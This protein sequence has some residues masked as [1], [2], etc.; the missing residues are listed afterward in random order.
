MMQTLRAFFIVALLVTGAAGHAANDTGNTAA[1]VTT[2]LRV[3]G[4]VKT[5]LVLGVDALRKLSMQHVGKLPL[6]CQ[7]GAEVG[8]LDNLGGVLLRDVLEQAVL[9]A[10]GHN[11]AKKMVIVATA[12]DGYRVVFSWGEVFNSALGE[13][14]VVVFEK[15]GRPLGDDSGRIAL[16]STQDTRTGPRHVKWL[17]DIEV[18]RLD[19]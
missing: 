4:A 19:D 17:R 7:T 9:D 15:D 10:P 5:P 3:T 8:S 14:I 13:G 6:V 1:L 2:E 12:S 11:D 16:V 18:R